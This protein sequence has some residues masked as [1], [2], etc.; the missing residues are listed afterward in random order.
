MEIV[1]GITALVVSI[2]AL[3]IAIRKKPAEKVVVKE[4]TTKVVYAPVEHP[5]T[6][7][8]EENIYTLDGALFV[9]GDVT[10]LLGNNK[11]K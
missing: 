8:E 5:F 7:N 2:V 9:R 10:C 4:E 6:Y 11:D 3:V 1:L